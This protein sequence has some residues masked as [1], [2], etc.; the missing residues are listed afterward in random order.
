MDRHMSATPT[1][2]ATSAAPASAHSPGISDKAAERGNPSFVWRDGQER[3][4]ALAQRWAPMT[5]KR[6]LEFGCGLGLY[7]NAIK[8]FT[9]RVY[10]FDI[11]VERLAVARKNGIDGTVG[12]VGE[13]LPFADASFDVV[14]SN[15]V[16]EHVSDDVASAREIV[17]V[18][19]P[20]GRAVIYVPNRRYL[21]E[22][23]GVYWRGRYYFG[24]KPFVNWLP[25][26]LR[27]KLAPHVRAYRG[28]E[29][30]ALFERTPS[31]V[32]ALTQ[33]SGG[34]DN[35]IRKL[36]PAGRALRAAMHAVDNTPLRKLALEHLIV[37]EKA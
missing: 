30:R 25:D 12:A 36:G 28:R 16:L 2:S 9:P 27:N 15:D 23:H 34:F 18:L 14:F 37:V 35:L 33:I 10:G 5:D 21:F 3:R 4:L 32:I 7:L 22:T 11:E 6:V 19:Q 31:R 20:G 1:N 29:L 13:R 24:N 17:R 26:S 8:R